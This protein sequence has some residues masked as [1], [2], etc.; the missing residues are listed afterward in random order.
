MDDFTSSNNFGIINIACRN[1]ISDKFKIGIEDNELSDILN[2]V[3]ETMK[4][5][6]STENFKT[7]YV[8]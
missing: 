3:I 8:I 5:E 7:I 6:F 2:H 1:M 4:A